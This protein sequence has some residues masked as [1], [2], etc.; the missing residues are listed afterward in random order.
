MISS[1]AVLSMHRNSGS[2]QRLT[3]LRAPSLPALYCTINSVP[4]AI[5]THDPGSL[6]SNSSTEASRPGA[7]SSYS[8]GW[9]LTLSY[10]PLPI[11][12][13]RCAYSRYTGTGFRPGPREPVPGWVRDDGPADEPSPSP[14]PEYK[15][16]TAPLRT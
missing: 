11:R 15:F 10:P 2:P 3:S 7:T 1:C 8:D 4:P 5:G 12:P 14:C 16:R 13:G 6:A 9:A